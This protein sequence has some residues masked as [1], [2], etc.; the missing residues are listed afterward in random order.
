M[1]MRVNS[2]GTVET[3]CRRLAALIDVK[4]FSGCFTPPLGRGGLYD[5]NCR[6]RKDM[7]IYRT[8]DMRKIKLHG[9]RAKSTRL[10]NCS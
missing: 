3:I 7:R 5:L 8:T 4:C 6:L 2:K 10:T 9:K 1:I